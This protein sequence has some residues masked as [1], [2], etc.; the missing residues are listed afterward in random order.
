M[1]KTSGRIS[2]FRVVFSRVGTLDQVQIWHLPSVASV[3][4]CHPVFHPQ[5]SLD[6]PPGTISCRRTLHGVA[7][8]IP[9][10]EKAKGTHLRP[11]C[12]LRGAV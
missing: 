1:G 7:A 6:V 4:V 2:R 5:G 12:C 10:S 9:A 8:N 11:L 3:P